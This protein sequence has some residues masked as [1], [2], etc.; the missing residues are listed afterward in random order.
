MKKQN[1]YCYGVFDKDGNFQ[2]LALSIRTKKQAREQEAWLNKTMA[3]G[4]RVSLVELV[5]RREGIKAPRVSARD[6]AEMY[7]EGVRLSGRA[8]TLAEIRRAFELGFK[9]GRESLDRPT[10]RRSTT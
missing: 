7:V 8:F 3:K 9:S 1:I 4:T 6:L 2:S 5:E 10:S